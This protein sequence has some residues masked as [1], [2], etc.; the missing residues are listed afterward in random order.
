V[1]GRIVGEVVVLSVSGLMMPGVEK[2]LVGC[3]LEVGGLDVEGR[4]DAVPGS[5]EL[6]S[7]YIT[8]QLLRGYKTEILGRVWIGSVD[9]WPSR[10][11]SSVAAS[12]LSARVGSWTVLSVCLTGNDVIVRAAKIIV[13]MD[14][15]DFFQ[16]SDVPCFSLFFSL[17]THLSK[18]PTH[19]R[20]V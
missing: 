13:P 20:H 15:N 10:L 9:G 18:Q 1:S 11:P 6:H 16:A 3:H 2:C 12:P 8:K 17:R 19:N 5:R 4:L 7:T 14:P